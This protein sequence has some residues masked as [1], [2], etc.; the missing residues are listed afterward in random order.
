M[1]LTFHHLAHRALVFA[2]PLQFNGAS[3]IYALIQLFECRSWRI[4][5]TVYV[6]K[7]K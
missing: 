5:F 3:N 7:A 4:E 2:S 1:D 6:F